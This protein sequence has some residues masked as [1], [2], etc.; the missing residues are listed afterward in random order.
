LP[1]LT[2]LATHI[3]YRAPAFFDDE[4][5]VFIEPGGLGRASI[6]LGFRMICEGDGR[7][8]AEG[9]GT[10]VGYDYDA[11]RSQ[12]IPDELRERLAAI[13]ACPAAAGR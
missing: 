13:S 8:V 1:G 6:Q 9:H 12:P 4:L 5:R 3:S 2:S 10:L 7:L 11:G